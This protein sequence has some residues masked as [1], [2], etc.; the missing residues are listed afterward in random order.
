M[1]EIAEKTVS[2]RKFL[3]TGT[4]AAG[5]TAGALAMPSVVT[6]Q[7]PIVLKMQSSWPATDVFQ[8][9]ATQYV[10]R[11]QKMSDDRLKIDLLPAGA[12]VGAFDVQDACHD[13]AIDA[14]HTVPVYW[15]GKH[16]GASLFGTGPV[17]GGT[18]TTWSAGSTRAAARISTASWC[19]TS[20]A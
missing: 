6:A 11:V 5:A 12:V 9:M 20:S 8:E 18:G 19:R 1:T 17:F 15:Y 13:G 14:A 4:I 3:K 7:S 2:R 10:D 16:K